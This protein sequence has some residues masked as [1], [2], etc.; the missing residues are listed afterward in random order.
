MFR[1]SARRLAFMAPGDFY[2]L[3]QRSSFSSYT[4]FNDS[5]ALARSF[6]RCS[7][8]EKLT[9]A[10]RVEA[11]NAE[12]ERAQEAEAQLHVDNADASTPAAAPV[13]PAAAKRA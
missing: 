9:C 3:S 10:E 6:Q 2:A 4:Q 1:L 12:M 11:I 5:C 8:A 13:T 7:P